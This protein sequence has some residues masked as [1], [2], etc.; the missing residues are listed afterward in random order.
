LG[1]GVAI[2]GAISWLTTD[3]ARRYGHIHWEVLGSMV[4]VCAGFCAGAELLILSGRI[5][6]SERQRQTLASLVGLPWS[7]GKI[8]RQK[9][10]GCLP[11]FLPW[12]LLALAGLFLVWEPLVEEF[13]D[14][15]YRGQ[16]RYNWSGEWNKFWRQNREEMGAGF[17]VVLQALLLIVTIVWFSLRIRRG[18]LPASIA[19]LVVWN[20]IFAL[21]I[22][23]MHSQDEYIGLFV[24]V[25]LTFPALTLMCR[26]V[27]LRVQTA[28]AED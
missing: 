23:E 5:L 10:L 27:Y 6:G 8:I 12:L 17:Y 13:T 21:C 22:D 9:I 28:A 1:L 18:A 14:A 25:A 11:V 2:F 24:G 16:F 7:T 4:I 15:Y 3:N 19:V 26:A 20:V